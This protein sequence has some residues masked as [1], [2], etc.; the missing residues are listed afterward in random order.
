MAVTDAALTPRRS[1]T[2]EVETGASLR[3]SIQIVFR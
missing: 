2:R 3:W 1:A